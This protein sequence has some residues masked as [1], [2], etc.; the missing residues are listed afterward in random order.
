MEA[1]DGTEQAADMV[2]SAWAAD[3]VPAAYRASRWSG[4][5]GPDDFRSKLTSEYA[6]FGAFH[7]N[8]PTG[9]DEYA[10]TLPHNWVYNPKQTGK[11][12]I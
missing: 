6:S 8:A 3:G 4:L 2:D 12:C 1:Y 10:L 11:G 9:T 5:F 7:G